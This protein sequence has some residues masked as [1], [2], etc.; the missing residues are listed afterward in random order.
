ME[1]EFVKTAGF[2]AVVVGIPALALVLAALIDG[3]VAGGKP[4]TGGG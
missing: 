2:F 3:G 4:Q 1:I